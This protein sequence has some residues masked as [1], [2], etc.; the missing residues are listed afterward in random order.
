MALQAH[1]C[2]YTRQEQAAALYVGNVGVLTDYVLWVYCGR[3]V[4]VLK[5]I[6]DV[7]LYCGCAQQLY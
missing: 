7:A 3:T 2:K 1:V 6:S 4:D 5:W